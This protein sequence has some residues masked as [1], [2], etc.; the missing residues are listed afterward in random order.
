MI[1]LFNTQ[2]F[3][4]ITKKDYLLVIPLDEKI[5]SKFIFL[6][7][8]AW[9]LIGDYPSLHSKAHITVNH[10]PNIEGYI[11]E[12]KL[13]YYQRKLSFVNDFK[14]NVS[15]FGFFRHNA[16]SYTIYAKVKPDNVLKNRLHNFDRT[17]SKGVVKTPHITIAKTVSKPKYEKLWSYFEHFKLECSFYADKI[18]VLETPTR[19]FN[20]LPMRQ[21][22]DI[23]LCLTK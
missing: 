14:V 9:E 21:K 23:R 20:S 19:K 6:K 11:F 10:D 3:I 16:N 18:T 22:V 15:G 4:K 8:K 12:K 7:L 2:P 5:V 13:I 1:Q 17:F